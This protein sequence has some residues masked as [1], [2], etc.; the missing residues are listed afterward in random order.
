M[1]LSMHTAKLKERC[2]T[3]AL[4]AFIYISCFSQVSYAQSDS[5]DGLWTNTEVF[6]HNAQ[7]IQNLQSKS[8]LEIANPNKVLNLEAKLD[9]LKNLLETAPPLSERK[10]GQTGVKIYLPIKDGSYAQFEAF[11]NSIFHSSTK[12]QFPSKTYKAFGS[13]NSSLMAHISIG[14][15]GFYA[16]IRGDGKTFYI[17]PDTSN[18]KKTGT[19]SSTH[20]GFVKKGTEVFSCDT[21]NTNAIHTSSSLL[22]NK[23]GLNTSERSSGSVLR[24]YKLAVVASP[25]YSNNFTSSESPVVED[26]QEAI[27]AAVDRVNMVLNQDLAINLSLVDAPDLIF[28]DSND[29]PLP[30]SASQAIWQVTEL[31]NESIGSSGYDIGHLFTQNGGGIAFLGG[32]CDSD[33]KGAGVS[34][35]NNSEQFDHEFF[36]IDILAHEL[37]HQFGANHT[38][39]ARSANSCSS[40]T[41]N[42]ST[43]VEPG[44]G[45]TIMS[46]AG[47]CAPQNIQSNSDDYFHHTSIHEILDYV[48]T[49]TCDS[50]EGSIAEPHDNPPTIDSIS[51][52]TSIPARTPFYLDASASDVDGENIFFTWEQTDAGNATS[53]EASMFIDSGNNPLFRSAMGGANQGLRYF[54]LFLSEHSKS[55]FRGEALP[56]SDRTLHFSVNARS[57]PYGR[58]SS[59]L[60]INII[61]HDIGFLL[62]HPEANS[63]YSSN[64]HI[65]LLWETAGSENSPISCNTISIYYSDSNST[66]PSEYDAV[67]TEITNDGK[68]TL[69]E[70]LDPSNNGRLLLSCDN[71]NFYST[72]TGSFS[73]V[74]DDLSFFSVDSDIESLQEGNSGQKLIIFTISRI[75]NVSSSNSIDFEFDFSESMDAS[76]YS[77]TATAGTLNFTEGEISKTIEFRINGDEDFESDE[78][79]VLVISNPDSGYVSKSYTYITVLNDDVAPEP[80]ASTETKKSKG[81][82]GTMQYILFLLCLPLI[83]RQLF[84]FILFGA[85]L[86]ITACSPSNQ[87]QLELH[88]QA[89]KLLWVEHANAKQDLESNFKQ[90][91]KDTKFLGI[92]LKGHTEIPGLVEEELV[93]ALAHGYIIQAGMGDVIF[94]KEHMHLREQFFIYANEYNQLLANKLFQ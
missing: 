67:E 33:F 77:T 68:H 59:N 54:P 49:Q 43:A 41:R 89:Q 23:L 55:L 14:S 65:E 70:L 22:K 44:S 83:L 17:D 1:I 13:N 29:F 30:S 93:K 85:L 20:Y 21:I 94:S 87:K 73:I 34:G 88:P 50:S 38:F 51:S 81:G 91:G 75:G 48:E 35:V 2:A 19:A 72:G 27:L 36:Y 4:L 26:V 32:V 15:R 52:S 90:Q 16:M 3:K 64:E 45:T 80:T 6:E 40:S 60:E 53:S 42:A 57:A 92:G 24:E 12:K 86:F 84:S 5:P 46:Y 7:H 71:N 76:D 56:A 18:Y 66:N 79:A 47:I 37:G 61:N 58:S 11:E 8:T 25:S 63:T 10:H 9:D 69:T 31:I 39:N 62:M 78:L 28:T 82:S 74:S